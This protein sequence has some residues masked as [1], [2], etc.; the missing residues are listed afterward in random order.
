MGSTVRV[1]NA[2]AIYTNT[3]RNK[4]QVL[5]NAVDPSL[6]LSLVLV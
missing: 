3:L 2:E 4:S 1:D 6:I 5:L